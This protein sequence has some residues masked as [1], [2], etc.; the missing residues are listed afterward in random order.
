MADYTIDIRARV[1]EAQRKVAHLDKQLDELQSKADFKINFP[2]LEQVAAGFRL[3][4][5][6]L[7]LVW[8]YGD[9][10]PIIGDRIG[11]IKDISELLNNSLE[12]TV[13]TLKQI[14]KFLPTT[15][16]TTGFGLAAS[17]ANELARATAN[18]GY[19][20][21]GLKQSVDIV[22]Q[23]FN[24][25][26]GDSRTEAMCNEMQGDSGLLICSWIDEPQSHQHIE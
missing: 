18:V 9:R 7:Q 3:V 20:I 24:G 4:G 23:A 6:G 25:F 8:K 17:G 15:V 1:E 16:L 22:R 5:K 2:N 11:D 13:N 19:T 10:L 14:P 21:F 12:R 26:A